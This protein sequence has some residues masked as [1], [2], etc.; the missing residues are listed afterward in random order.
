MNCSCGLQCVGVVFPWWMS[1]GLQG[2]RGK[3]R[4]GEADGR[5]RWK[6]LCIITATSSR[7]TRQTNTSG[8]GVAFWFILVCFFLS[9]CC[10]GK[11]ISTSEKSHTNPAHQGKKLCSR[12]HLMHHRAF[13]EGCFFFQHFPKKQTLLGANYVKCCWRLVADMRLAGVKCDISRQFVMLSG[14][15]R[16]RSRKVYIFYFFF[17]RWS[18]LRL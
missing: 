13:F 7:L 15:F 10:E 18:L 3:E 4:G 16:L 9:T 11:M 14:F 8:V 5:A 12:L 6:W 17:V 2:L 1:R